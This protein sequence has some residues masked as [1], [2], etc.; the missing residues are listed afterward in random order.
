MNVPHI[1]SREGICCAK[2]GRHQKAVQHFSLAIAVDD[3][4]SAAEWYC[5]RSASYVALE[6]FEMAAEDA[7]RAR[8]ARVQGE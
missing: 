4:L 8:S 7:I 2:L 1:V 6:Q 3:E 5:L